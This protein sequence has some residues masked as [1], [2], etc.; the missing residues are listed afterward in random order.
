MTHDTAHPA[1]HR[2]AH[3]ICPLCEACCGLVLDIARDAQGVE[4]VATVRGDDADPFSRGYVC[5]K[6]I[7]LKDLHSDPD[8]L[9]QPLIR[10]NGQHVPATWDEAFAEIARGL[11]DVQARHGKGAVGLTLGN[12]IVHK[13]GLTLTVPTLA[14]ALG[15]RHVYS[16]SSLDQIPRQLACGLMYGHWLSVPVPDIDRTD[17]LLVIGAN[18]VASN[19]SMWTVPD[20]RGRAKA[21]RQRGGRLTVI[22]PRR[23]ETARIADDYQPIRPGADV[24]LLAAM[25]HTLFA[26]G[27]VRLG[28]ASVVV[29]AA[30]V[31]GVRAAVAPFTPDAVAER[32][33]VPADTIRR[34]ARELAAA[35]RAAVYGRIGTNGQTFGTLSAWLIDVL[36]V[37]TGRLD[38]EGGVM[39]PKAAAMAANTV[40]KPGIGRGVGTGRHHSR[41]SGAPEVM[42]EWPITCLAEEIETPATSPEQPAVKALITVA[43]NPVLSAPGS[44]R[45]AAALDTLDF[46][47]SVDIYLNETTRHANVI[48]PGRSP[49]EDG[50]FDVAFGQLS[51]RNHARYSPPVGLEA[52]GQPAEWEILLRLS[53]IAQGRG[54]GGVVDVAALDDRIARQE[55]ERLAGDR[56]DAAFAEASRWHG[57][58]RRLDLALRAGPHGDDFGRRAGGLRLAALLDAPSGV[59]LGALVPRLPEV[60]RTPSGRVDLAPP[61]LLGDLPRALAALHEPA[62]PLVII[63]RR[64]V[65][66]NNSWMHNLPTLAKGP[67]RG[68]MQ[69]HPADAQQIGLVEGASAQ[70]RL[71][72]NAGRP[73][74]H[75]TVQIHVDDSVMPGVVC[76]PHGWGHDQPG[77]RLSIAAER[78]GANLNAVLDER[79]RDPLSGN[80]VLSG[81]AVVVE[82]LPLT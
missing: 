20:F 63:G 62:P 43:S 82:A 72:D 8:R 67:F 73:D 51:M 54:P 6:A 21:L 42:G 81:V 65:R 35:P 37:L 22:D 44:P 71:A 49:L 23:T 9:R 7:A 56:A 16:A 19:G 2:T 47:V 5:P 61:M 69:M 79:L 58:E 30:D 50:H 28:A 31:E 3:R 76:L 74:R 59:D 14:K 26:E 78:P 68:A 25:A 10:R 48:L 11:G 33:A 45:L 1:D 55:A 77:M 15:T 39:F 46:M 40:G 4:H 41:V 66:S 27:L 52:S 64:D 57:P 18:P 60:L 36:N 75:I 53:E 17:W 38:A 70:V 34:L 32:C 29:S 24:F 80:A 12:P 13:L